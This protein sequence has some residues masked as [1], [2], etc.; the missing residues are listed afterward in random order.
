[1]TPF[2]CMGWKLS[3]S[4]APSSF[5][6]TADFPSIHTQMWYLHHS[7]K[8]DQINIV[9]CPPL[10]NSW[11]IYFYCCRS[12]WFSIGLSFIESWKDLPFSVGQTVWQTHCAEA[13]ESTYSIK[14]INKSSLKKLQRGVMEL[15]QVSYFLGSSVLTLERS[16]LIWTSNHWQQKKVRLKRPRPLLYTIFFTSYDSIANLF[17]FPET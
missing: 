1:M 4:F 10:I 7:I 11:P 13:R 5:S 12:G 3:S 17:T 2:F 16:E 8:D 14:R 6:L 15:S 9:L